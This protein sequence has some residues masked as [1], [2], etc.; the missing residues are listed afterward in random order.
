VYTALQE[1]LEKAICSSYVALEQQIK[2]IT[3]R[4]FREIIKI[5]KHFTKQRVN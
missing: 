5:L 1:V 2:N 3:T 4:G